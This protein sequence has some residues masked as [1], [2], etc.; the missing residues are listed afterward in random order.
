MMTVLTL[1][2]FVLCNSFK[3]RK[4][5]T[6]YNSALIHSTVD[7]LSLSQGGAY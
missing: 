5:L 1:N 7:P 4:C 2:V 3:Y 6:S